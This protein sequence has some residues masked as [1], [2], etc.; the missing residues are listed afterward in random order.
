MECWKYQFLHDFESFFM[1]HFESR[2]IGYNVARVKISRFYGLLIWF[3][4]H[5]NSVPFRIKEML[6]IELKLQ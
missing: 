3:M 4:F 1:A 5:Y 2:N 6:F